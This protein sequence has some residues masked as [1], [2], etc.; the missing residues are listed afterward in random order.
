MEVSHDLSYLGAEGG[1][2]IDRKDTP[3]R[4]LGR[5]VPHLKAKVAPCHHQVGGFNN[6]RIATKN[7]PSRERLINGLPCIVIFWR[8]CTH[9]KPEVRSRND[10]APAI[11]PELDLSG[12]LAELTADLEERIHH[13]RSSQS[14]LFNMEDTPNRSSF[15]V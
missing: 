11:F 10:P 5:T 13:R 9:Y 15:V 4:R 12:D 8:V 3:C 2:P 6:F 7:D 1:V 14:D